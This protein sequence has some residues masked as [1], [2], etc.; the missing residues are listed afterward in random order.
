MNGFPEKSGASGPLTIP[1][2]PEQLTSANFATV[3]LHDLYAQCPV[4]TQI[5]RKTELNAIAT[6]HWKILRGMVLIRWPITSRSS[7]E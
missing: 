2:I 3:V 4:G 6:A 5:L 7:C 1:G